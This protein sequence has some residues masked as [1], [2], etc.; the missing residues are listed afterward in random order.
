MRIPKF[1]GGFW[2]SA[3]TVLFCGTFAIYL[4]GLQTKHNQ[5]MY[6]TTL[7][8]SGRAFYYGCRRGMEET[9]PLLSDQKG[10]ILSLPKDLADQLCKDMAISYVQQAFPGSL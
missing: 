8:I 1:S 2:A 5:V 7:M 3:I 9:A 4:M 6:H 10:P